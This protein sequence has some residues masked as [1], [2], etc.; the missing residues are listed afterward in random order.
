MV[1]VAESCP[2][3]T[4]TVPGTDAEDALL[5]SDI[6]NPP[7]GALPVRLT[8]PVEAVPPVTVTGLILNRANDAGAMVSFAVCC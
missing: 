2:A 3:A 7:V 8:V 4:V 6:D 5:V 1:N